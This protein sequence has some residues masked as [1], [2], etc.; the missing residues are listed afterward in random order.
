MLLPPSNLERH[1]PGH[2]LEAKEASITGLLE[3]PAP[4]ATSASVLEFGVAGEAM[5]FTER[6]VPDCRELVIKPVNEIVRGSER[7][8]P[9]QDKEIIVAELLERHDY[10]V[11]C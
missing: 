2:V 9:V 8:N 4:G 5:L 6:A 7:E 11:L 10:F 3:H 1:N